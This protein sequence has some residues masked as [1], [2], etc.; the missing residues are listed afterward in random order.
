MSK[1]LLQNTRNIGIVAH[2]D[3]GKTTSTERILFYTGM[4]HRIGE[5]DAG[6]TVTDWMKQERERGITITSA[7]V[8]CQWK[9]YTINIIDTPGHVDFTIEVERCLRVLDGA[10]VVF[11][12]VGGVEPQSETVWRQADKF[13]IPKVVF[14]NKMDRVGADFERVCMQIKGKFGV[15]PV[16]VVLPDGGAQDFKG[17]VDLI[18]WKYLTFDE[19]SMGANVTRGDVPDSIVEVALRHRKNLLEAVADADE[20]AMEQYLEDDT[21]D[22]LKI[23]QVVRAMTLSGKA[24]PVLAGTALKNKG[25]Q[26]L[27]GAIADF[28][29]SPMDVPPVEGFSLDG[30]TMEKRQPNPQLPFAALAFKIQDDVFANQLTYLRIYSG[31][32]KIQEPVLNA[33][34]GKKERMSKLVRMYANRREELRKAVAGDIV[35]AVGLRWTKTGDTLCDVNKPLLLEKIEFPDPVVFRAIEPKMKADEN[36][37]EEILERIVGEDPSFQSRTD[38]ETGQRIICGMGELHLEVI[39]TRIQ[40]DYRIPVI[41]GKPQVAFRETVTATAKAEGTFDKVIAGKQQCASVSVK[42]GPADRGAGFVY[43][44]EWEDP[45][46]PENVRTAMMESIRDGMSGGVLAGY[47]CTDVHV[48]VLGGSYDERI[49]TE[50]AVRA[51][52][53]TALR[54]ALRKASCVL[55]EPVMSI[56]IVTLKDTVGDVIGD[57]NSRKGKVIEME[58][59]SEFQVITGM[60]PLRETFGYAT[61]LRSLTQGRATYHMQFLHFEPME[62]KG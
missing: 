55:M 46:I 62:T 16:V 42:V 49:S 61:Q 2:I 54:D 53:V 43:D 6:T 13:R 12:A 59:R 40:D 14:V 20:E 22:A 5:V 36:R 58:L 10:V 11:C 7:S 50:M 32:I 30:E 19:E 48:T 37:L 44:D 26:P 8:S 4:I 45:G 33:T 56:E 1:E 28:L 34:Q 60:I 29:P 31:T 39:V 52:S 47:Q 23:R 38:P 3:A 15:E 41:V 17:V 25:I 24:V 27:L 21:I 57:F 51:A 9:I 18:E 35:A